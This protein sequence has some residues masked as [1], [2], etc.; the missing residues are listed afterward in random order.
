MLTVN[1]DIQDRLIDGQAGNIRHTQFA[2]DKGCKGYVKI[3]DEQSGLKAIRS[4]CLGRQ[5]FLLKNLKL[6]FK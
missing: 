3:S 4:S 6:G 2:Q 5:N 1:I